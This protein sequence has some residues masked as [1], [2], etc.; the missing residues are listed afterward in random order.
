MSALYNLYKPWHWVDLYLFYR[1]V[2]FGPMAFQ[3]REV[4]TLNFS[5]SFE[6]CDLKV[7]RYRRLIDLMKWCE[8]SRSRS[9]LDP[10]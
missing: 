9:F 2:N 7:S 10:D 5:G 6:A 3:G 8:Y 4:K 1:K